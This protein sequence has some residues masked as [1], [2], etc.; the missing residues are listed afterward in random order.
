[1][2]A[3]RKRHAATPAELDFSRASLLVNNKPLA[4]IVCSAPREYVFVGRQRCDAATAHC[5]IKRPCTYHKLEREQLRLHELRL[6]FLTTSSVERMRWIAKG[7]PRLQAALQR[8]AT[9]YRLSSGGVRMFDLCPHGRPIQE[10]QACERCA[11]EAA[12]CDAL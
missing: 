3:V 4:L 5:S 7:L 12:E 6:V 8:A 11:A 9:G 10:W 2:S 1:M